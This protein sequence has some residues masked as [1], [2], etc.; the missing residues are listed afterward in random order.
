[1]KLPECIKRIES[2]RDF[3][4]S[5]S[6]PATKKLA[7]VPTRFGTENIPKN[8]YLIIPK[9]SSERR[10]YIPVGFMGPDVL[11]SD[12]VFIIPNATLYH[13]GILTS[14]VHNA[15]M[16]A[17]AG[18]LE[19]RYRYS[20]DIVYNNFPWPAVTETQRNKVEE[21]AQMILNAREHYPDAS[22]ADLYGNLILFP[23]LM[24]AHRANDAAVLEA[25][26]FP[27]DASEPDIVARLFK[28]YQELT[29]NE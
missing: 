14:S 23:D 27:K 13:F 29:T 18:R 12:L 6:R 22:M 3:R 25:Y 26:G 10:Q 15:W 8:N 1:M 7:D 9:V 19:M 4:A 21:T 11:S 5:S 17:V 2:V 20:K 28:M 24:K 16:R